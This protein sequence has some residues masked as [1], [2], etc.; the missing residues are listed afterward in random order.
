[1]VWLALSLG[2][3]GAVLGIWLSRV[4]VIVAGSI[5]LALLCTI[6]AP[7]AG[8]AL[9]TSVGYAFALMAALQGGYL[10]GIVLLCAA[11]RTKPAAAGGSNPHRPMMPAD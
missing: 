11:S 1:M 3:V 9:L 2:V 7:L 4:Y 6:A 10:S 5:A 8:W